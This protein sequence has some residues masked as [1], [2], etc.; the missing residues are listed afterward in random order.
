MRKGFGLLL[1]LLTLILAFQNCSQPSKSLHE[2]SGPESSKG[3]GSYDLNEA[4]KISFYIPSRSSGARHELVVDL[5]TGVINQI[6]PD[7]N[8]SPNQAENCLNEAETEEL[9]GLVQ[10]AKICEGPQPKPNQMCTMIYR[11]PYAEIHLDEEKISLG[12]STSGCSSGPDLCE[13]HQKLFQE[14]LESIAQNL[15]QKTCRE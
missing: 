10:S 5:I 12:E 14:K 2:E 15:D 1:I 3:V 9:R 6:N 7:Q 4:T 8:S 13:P 11:Y